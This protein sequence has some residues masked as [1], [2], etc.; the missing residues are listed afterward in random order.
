MTKANVHVPARRVGAG[1]PGTLAVGQSTIE[2]GPERTANG[3]SHARRF[4][5]TWTK[6]AARGRAHID[7]R[8][9]S[10]LTTEIM[11]TL[12]RP[13]SFGPLWVPSARKRLAGLLANALAYEVE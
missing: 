1:L 13:E 5:A 12:E 3:G 4:E 6:G 11:V 2:L 8:P 7:I 10:K 9:T